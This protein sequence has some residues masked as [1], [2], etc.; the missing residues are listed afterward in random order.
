MARI[1]CRT[2]C[3]V[4]LLLLSLSLTTRAQSRCGVERWP[5]KVLA[6]A[7]T[8]AVQFIPAASSVSELADLPRPNGTLPNAARIAPHERTVFRIRAVLKQVIVESDGDVHLV[9]QDTEDPTRTMIGEIPDSTCAESSRHA[10]DFAEAGRALRTTPLGAIVEIDG[11]GFFDFFH[12]QRGVAP[13][14]I[15]LHP[16][17][18]LRVIAV[19][20]QHSESIIRTTLNIPFFR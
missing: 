6:D 9:L 3:V 11:V 14:G 4:T 20:E 1:L 17:L 8:A 18:A 7:D 15:E 19:P 2:G 12:G 16:I 13:N 10:A 5:V